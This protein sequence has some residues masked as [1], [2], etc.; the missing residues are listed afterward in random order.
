ESGQRDLVAEASLQQITNAVKAIDRQIRIDCF[1][2]RSHFAED[3]I[4]IAVGNDFKHKARRLTVLWKGEIE[5]GRR[6]AAQESTVVF[7]VFGDADYGKRLALFLW[8]IHLKLPPDRVFAMEEVLHH[9]FVD[10]SDASGGCSIL[11]VDAT[12]KKNGNSE[13]S[14]VTGSNR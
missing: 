6:P 12:S 10:Y 11:S 8:I 14:E 1:D 5:P 2:L 13:G 7:C 3:R 4:G 9:S